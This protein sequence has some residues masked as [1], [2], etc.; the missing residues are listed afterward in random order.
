MI[1]S[2]IAPYREWLG[3][4]EK[5]KNLVLPGRIDAGSRPARFTTPIAIAIAT[6]TATATATV[7]GDSA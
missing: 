2:S 1:L 3:E 7:M 4:R 5:E 6:A